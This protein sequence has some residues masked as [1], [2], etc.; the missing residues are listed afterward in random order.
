[1]FGDGS[2]PAR[3]Q[4]RPG[5]S[6]EGQKGRAKEWLVELL[7]DPKSH[8][9]GTIIPAYAARLNQIQMEGLAEHNAGLR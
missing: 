9:S 7:R 6:Y 8:N 2:S 1:M 5:L 3:G 4:G